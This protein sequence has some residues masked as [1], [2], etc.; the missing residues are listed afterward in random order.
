MILAL[1][2]CGGN[3]SGGSYKDSDGAVKLNMQMGFVKSVDA[4]KKQ[5]VVDVMDMSK[6]E[7]RREEDGERPDKPEEFDGE[8]S[9]KPDTSDDKRPKD[10]DKEKMQ[11]EEKTFTVNANAIIQ[12]EDGSTIA[13]SEL[14]K[15]VMIQFTVDQEEVTS[16]TIQKMGRHN[17]E[18]KEDDDT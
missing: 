13:L 3:S 1:T 16:I 17:E 4:D 6:M 9:D 11:G 8:P 14:E 15:N 18:K 5:I 12:N 7:K 2:G 10:F